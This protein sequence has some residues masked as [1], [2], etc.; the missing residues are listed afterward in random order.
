VDRGFQLACADLKP[1]KRFVVYSGDERFP[2]AAD[3][4]AIGMADLGWALQDAK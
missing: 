4:D 2:L 3:I 1:N